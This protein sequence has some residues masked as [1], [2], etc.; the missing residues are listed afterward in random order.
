MPNTQNK[1][2]RRK[3]TAGVEREKRKA[4]TEATP[5][6][7]EDKGTNPLA[8]ANDDL[9]PNHLRNSEDLIYESIM[10][11]GGEAFGEPYR[12]GLSSLTEKVVKFFKQRSF[13][14]FE[15]FEEKPTKRYKNK[16]TRYG[17]ARHFGDYNVR[18]ARKKTR[19]R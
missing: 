12:I 2:K 8:E 5:E 15:T 11:G 17:A 4:R 19:Q 16:F 3:K 6:R 18:A 7:F 14:G 13:F 9:D 10:R 1:S